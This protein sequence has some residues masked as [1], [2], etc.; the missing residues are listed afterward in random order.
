MD[1]VNTGYAKNFFEGQIPQLIKALNRIA[2]NQEKALSKGSRI[3]QKPKSG[4]DASSTPPTSDTIDKIFVCYEENSAALYAEAGNINKVFVTHDIELAREWA[5]RSAKCAEDNGYRP[6]A[7]MDFD[8]SMD[9]I[10]DSFASMW[11]YLGKKE[12]AR[13]NY[14]IC[15]DAYSLS[16]SRELL[17]QLFA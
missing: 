3:E 10:G 13:E 9:K 5:R 15:V 6:I 4:L 17:D 7:S 14:G 16:Q 1:F 11:V 2:D 12:N 8:E